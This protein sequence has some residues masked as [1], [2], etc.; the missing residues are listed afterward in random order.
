MLVMPF[1][2]LSAC[3][4]QSNTKKSNK[5]NTDV[6]EITIPGS[7]SPS[8][9][10]ETIDV[11]FEY[12]INNLTNTNL[13]VWLW[14]CGPDDPSCTDP[15]EMNFGVFY[16]GQEWEGSETISMSESDYGSDFYYVWF[17]LDTSS[18]DLYCDQGCTPVYT[19]VSDRNLIW[20]VFGQDDCCY[21]LN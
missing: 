10:E 20:S 1:I 8:E 18:S 12:S 14:L 4:E 19:Y 3:S 2:I 11:V 5:Q 6:P 13:E 9:G 15:Y 16:E 17:G 7:S 21:T